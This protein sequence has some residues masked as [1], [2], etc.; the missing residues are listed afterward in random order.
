M[1]GL[2]VTAAGV[3]SVQPEVAG[4]G[5]A[6]T[7]AGGIG[8]IGAGLAQFGSGVLQFAGAG[9]YSNAVNSVLTLG[10]SFELGNFVGFSYSTST[11]TG[12]LFDTFQSI[13]PGVNSTQTTCSR[14]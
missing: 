9:N 3:I 12:D 8:S 7:A 6:A 1:L 13:I 4:A 11:V 10:S 2:G 14:Q 5:L